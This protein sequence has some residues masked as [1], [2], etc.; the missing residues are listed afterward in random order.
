MG[1]SSISKKNRDSKRR[2]GNE[3]SHQIPIPPTIPQQIEDQDRSDKPAIF[4]LKIEDP[5]SQIKKEDYGETK[6]FHQ[7]PKVNTSEKPAI[8]T[9]KTDD[10]VSL[11]KKEDY[12]ETKA[13]HHIPKVQRPITI[14]CADLKHKQISIEKSFEILPLEAPCNEIM[15]CPQHELATEFYCTENLC[16]IKGLHCIKC[17]NNHDSAHN[18]FHKFPNF[19]FGK[20]EIFNLLGKGGFGV[21]FEVRNK[22]KNQLMALKIIDINDLLKADQIGTQDEYRDMIKGEINLHKQIRNKNIIEYYDSILYEQ[23]NIWVIELELAQGSLSSYLDKLKED[24]AQTLFLEICQGVEYMHKN[25]IIHR[26]LKPGNILIKIEKNIKIPK[27]ADFGG[28]KLQ[29]L[30]ITQTKKSLHAGTDAYLPPE[31]LINLNAEFDMSS[32]IWALGIIYHQILTGKHPFLKHIKKN[33]LQNKIQIAT[34]IEKCNSDIIS[35]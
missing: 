19:L 26:D 11:I 9:Q 24:E 17:L 7:I 34:S 13:F 32:D 8:L 23:E 20:Y 29:T 3:L 25:N 35:G 15:L 6:A 33:V 16:E 31:M 1:N 18:S 5:V 10:P 14:K 21:V 28:A 2:H 27:I 22:L 30:F 4:T 12:G